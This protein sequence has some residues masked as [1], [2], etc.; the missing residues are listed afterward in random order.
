MKCDPP[1]TR[2]VRRAE[3]DFCD[4][5][6]DQ[7][8]RRPGDHRGDQAETVDDQGCERDRARPERARQRDSAERPEW[9]TEERDGVG[10][11]RD[12]GCRR[13]AVRIQEVVPGRMKSHRQYHE[14]RREEECESTEPFVVHA[15]IVAVLWRRADFGTERTRTKGGGVSGNG[16]GKTDR[17]VRRTR[18]ALGDA[19]VQ[20]ATEHPFDEITV[21]Q[22]LDRAGVARSTFYEHFRDKNDLFLTDV[23]HLLDHMVTLMKASPDRDRRLVPLRELLEHIAD[24]ENFYRAIEASSSIDAVLDLVEAWFVRLIDRHIRSNVALR[25]LASDTRRLV[26]TSQAR[27]AMSILEEWVRENTSQEP[28]RLDALFHRMAWSAIDAAAKA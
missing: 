9:E 28:A 11:N 25:S 17:R 21:Q 26:A 1:C 10:Q 7:S 13:R 22:I 23:E 24:V 5:G 16:A 2:I 6:A 4:P 18:A 20:L 8:T 27:A 3:N 12:S 19:L 15:A 14:Q